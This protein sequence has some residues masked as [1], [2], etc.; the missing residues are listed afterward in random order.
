MQKKKPRKDYCHAGRG[1]WEI[2]NHKGFTKYFWEGYNRR[3]WDI[4]YV[5]SNPIVVIINFS[6]HA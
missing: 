1:P 2:K 6:M 3:I 4:H 5:V